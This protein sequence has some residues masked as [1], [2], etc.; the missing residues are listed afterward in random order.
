METQ[1]GRL[2][3]KKRYHH[4][5]HRPL[6]SRP[7][8]RQCFM[9]SARG[10]GAMSETRQDKKYTP[11]MRKL[12]LCVITLPVSLAQPIRV[13]SPFLFFFLLRPTLDSGSEVAAFLSRLE[14]PKHIQE[15]KERPPTADRVEREKRNKKD[16]GTTSLHFLSPSLHP[17]HTWAT[18]EQKGSLLAKKKIVSPSNPLGAP[19]KEQLNSTDFPKHL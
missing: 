18:T 19:Q 6:P 16:G 3:R 14:D 7:P 5:P 12:G 17:F 9:S 2:S 15:P 11:R 13:V 10:G 1:G 8:P 4:F